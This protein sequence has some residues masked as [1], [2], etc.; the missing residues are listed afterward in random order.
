MKTHLRHMSLP[1]RLLHGLVASAVLV[2]GALDAGGQGTITF[3]GRVAFGD[4][5]YYELGMSFQVAVPTPGTGS[6]NHDG[7]VIS[8]AITYPWNTPSNSTPYM[9]FFQQFSPDDY[10]AFSLTDGSTF[11][12]TSVQLADPS[13]PSYSAL[14]ITFK[15][16]KADGSII[17]E[18]FTTP[19]A[20]ANSLLNYQFNSSFASGLTSVNILATRWA[21]DN[22]VFTVPEPDSAT[23]LVTGLLAFSIRAGRGRGKR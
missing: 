12:L 21:M 22:L 10:V 20:G 15:G 8:P 18:T 2:A 5:N 9:L 23:L 14:P 17:R 11:G 16:F 19:G 1:L 6:P 7:L 13:S 4:T 3:S